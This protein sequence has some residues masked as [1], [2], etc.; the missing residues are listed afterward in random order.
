MTSIFNVHR[1]NM[2]KLFPLLILISTT[3]LAAK[4]DVVYTWKPIKVLDGDTIKFEAPWVPAPIKPEISVRVLGVDTPE[5]KPRNKCEQ[6]DALA[7]KASKF[8]KE[9]VANAK[10][11][12]VKLE[13]WDKYGGRVLGTVIIDGKVLSDE[14]IANGLAR[15]YFG[16]AKASWCE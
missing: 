15:P 16:E 1:I 5:K 13:D 12:Q 6:E 4:E 7:Q 10:T 9:L 3:A 14:L 2:K 8:T 11:V